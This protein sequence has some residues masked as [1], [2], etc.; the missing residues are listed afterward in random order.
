[1]KNA[2]ALTGGIASG[3]STVTSLLKLHGYTVLEADAVAREALSEK[4]AEV[5]GL[6]GEEILTE[7]VIDRK[8]LGALV[9]G[10]ESK[11]RTLEGILHPLIRSKLGEACDRLEKFDIP[12]FV[13]IPLFYETG[14]YPIARV[15]LIYAP[16]DIQ[17]HRL[18][19]RD[20]LSE[21]DARA[22]I[23]AQISNDDKKSRATWV[24]NNSGD[25][26]HLQRQIDTFL[27]QL[28]SPA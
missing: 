14:A 28:R 7:G 22:R 15:L 4:S 5:V 6:F 1:M 16:A 13:D 12:Y 20:G 23:D 3:K 11:R 25:L 8:K 19:E 21:A 10:D 24:V 27:A 2:I 18:M 26:K 17:L 9:F